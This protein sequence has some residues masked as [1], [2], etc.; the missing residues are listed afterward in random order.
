MGLRERDDVARSAG[1]DTPGLLPA[2]HAAPRSDVLAYLNSSDHG[3]TSP[4]A[5]ERRARRGPNIVPTAP[6]PSLL[7][8]FLRQFASPLIYILLLAAALSAWLGEWADTAFIA[9]VLLLNAGIGTTQEYRAQQSA[10]ALREMVTTRADVVRDGDLVEVDAADLV[11]GDVVLLASGDKVPA[12]LRLLDSHSLFVD[13][14]PLTGE[15]LPVEKDAHAQVLAS[16]GLSDR[17]TAAYAGTLVTYGRSRGVVTATGADTEIGRLAGQLAEPDRAEPPLFTRMRRF[18]LAVGVAIGIVAALMSVV[19]VVR[20]TEWHQVLLVAVALAVSAIPEGLPVAL[21]V[22]LAVA[23]AR[24]ARRNVIVRRLLAIEAL[25]SCT[26]IASDKT[27]TLTVNQLTVTDVVIPGCEPWQVTGAGADPVGELLVPAGTGEPGRSVVEQLAR[28]AVLCN[29]AVLARDGESWVHRGAAVDVALLVFGHKLGVTR[30]RAL[31]ARPTIATIPFESE[32]RYAA[33]MHALEVEDRV[34]IVVKGALERVLPMC[35]QMAVPG[36]TVAIDRDGMLAA[37]ERIAARGLRV[38]AIATQI[39][40]HAQA[41]ELDPQS[42]HGLTLLG[43]VGM[44]DPLRPE[45]A[46]AIATCRQ[47]GVDVVMVTGDHPITALTIARQIGL[48]EHEDEVVTGAELQRATAEGDAA[49]DALTAG[50]KV[51]ARVEPAQKLTITESMTRHGHIV[52]VTGDGAN[53]APA[54]HHAHVGVAMGQSGTDVAREAAELVLTDDRFTSIAAGVDEG[55]V[56]YANVRKVIQLLITTGAGELVLVLAA[57]AIGL[58]LP[59]LA[60]QLLWLNLVTNGIQDVALAFEPAEGDE[61]QRPPRPPREPIFNWLMIERVLVA[62]A[63]IGGVSLATY[64]WLLSNG[65]TEQAARNS[66][67]LLVVLFE[68]IQAFNSRSETRSLFAHNPRGNRLLIGGTLLAQ[69]VHIGAMHLPATQAVLGLQPVTLAHWAGLLGLA[70]L[71][72]IAVELHKAFWR[73]RLAHRHK[74][75][76]RSGGRLGR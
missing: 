64:W 27:G 59:L 62:A 41:A 58:P 35:T 51:F 32:R 6:P 49:T 33:T 55:R 29:E 46:A 57:L 24:M 50:A 7:G 22:A 75:A 2:A 40:D 70:L 19:L 45:A 74:H 16:A 11:V 48:A 13:E 31:D 53:D 3:L 36:A 9:A 28:A 54:L 30:P 52:A 21:T 1:Y 23:A 34:E 73:H 5:A 14:S 72:L 71:L 39:R 63:V 67:V 26:I 15:S 44:I 38:L 37:G 42:L 56:A 68:N 65:W 47:A 61:M 69:L 18:T 43:M 76:H 25:G 12:D 10:L 8:V 66:V 4:E 60:V 17:L 20:G